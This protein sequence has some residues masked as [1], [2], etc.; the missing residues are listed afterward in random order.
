MSKLR[1]FLDT[2]LFVMVF[3][4]P[5]WFWAVFGLILL[6]SFRSYYE[7]IAAAFISDMLYGVFGHSLFFAPFTLS[8]ISLFAFTGALIWRQKSLW[9][10]NNYTL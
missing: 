9:Y 6:F 3:T 4:A 1:I 7:I 5:W 10:R 8:F 2:A